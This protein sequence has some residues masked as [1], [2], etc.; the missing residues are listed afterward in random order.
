MRGASTLRTVTHLVVGVDGHMRVRVRT[1]KYLTAVMR[2]CWVVS[3]KWLQA[4][5]AAGRMVPEEPYEVKVG[6]LPCPP[7]ASAVQRLCPCGA[8]S[9]EAR[10]GGSCALP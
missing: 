2:G 4:C 1:L 3:G 10:P 5:L 8:R 7:I 9:P 6:P